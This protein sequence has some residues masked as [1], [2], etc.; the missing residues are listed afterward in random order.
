MKK[1]FTLIGL[2]GSVTCQIGVLPLYYLKKE[3][4]KMPYYACEESASCPS[5]ALHIFRRKMLHTAEPC[6]IRSAFTL[7]E[8]LVV[9]AIIAILAAMLLPALQQ[10]RD[11]AK[12]SSCLN[13]FSQIGRLTQLYIADYKGYYPRHTSKT[14]FV[15]GDPYIWFVYSPFFLYT[16]KKANS[17][18]FASIRLYN[19]KKIVINQYACPAAPP[20]PSCF[21]KS[22]GDGMTVCR[23]AIEGELYVTLGFNRYFHGDNSAQRKNTIP[24]SWVKRPAY[25]VYMADNCGW[26]NIDYRCTY[27]ERYSEDGKGKSVPPRHAGGANFL[28]ADGHTKYIKYAAYPDSDKV[29]Y[30]GLT[31]NPN[32]SKP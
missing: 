26:G 2:L 31:W 5:G 18:Y 15:A 25:T 28:Y 1:R 30:N 17:E 27:Q 29:S 20:A 21:V 7:I 9:I 6:F 3:N 8:L 16:P 14:G 13:N 11:K 32:A 10:A 19:K 12:S 4:K 22:D 23:P 24:S